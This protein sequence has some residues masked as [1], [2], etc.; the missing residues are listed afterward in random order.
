MLDCENCWY[1]AYDEQA[2]EFF[3]ALYLDE[4]EYGHMLSYQSGKCRY[5]RPS[6]DEY[7][8]VKKQN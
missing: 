3:C 4:D 7:E 1:N 2:D 8:I 6:G 5:F